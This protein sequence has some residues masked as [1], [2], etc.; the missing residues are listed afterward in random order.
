MI[1][2][3]VAAAGCITTVAI[4][5]WAGRY[6]MTTVGDRAFVLDRFTGEIRLC[7]AEGCTKIEDRSWDVNIDELARKYGGPSLKNSN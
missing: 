6:S 7:S 5:L 3:F 4:A 1:W 2:K